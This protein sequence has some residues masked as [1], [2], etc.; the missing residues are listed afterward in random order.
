MFARC[1]KDTFINEVT[2]L[3]MIFLTRL[4]S[5]SGARG[6]VPLGRDFLLIYFP[7][8]PNPFPVRTR[9]EDI[10]LRHFRQSTLVKLVPLG[11]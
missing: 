7:K 1:V 4:P 9:S 3:V 11:F 6:G 5:I 10:R 2:E 8:L